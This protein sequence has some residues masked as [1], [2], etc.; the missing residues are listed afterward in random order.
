MNGLPDQF[1]LELGDTLAM[2]APDGI[3]SIEVQISNASIPLT[4]DD[5]H[6]RFWIDQ[7]SGQA[8]MSLRL[9]NLTS[10]VLNPP[11][12]P[13]ALGSRGNSELVMNR[14]GSSPFSVLLED[15][16]ERSDKFLGLSG[17][18]HLDPLPSQ[19]YTISSI[20]R[21]FRHDYNP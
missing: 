15:V 8:S 19:C 2:S 9:S 12:E 1:E 16:S 17:K 14:T 11:E 5:D 13:G 18:I 4:M 10:I 20:F 21:K 6:A 3:G 7:V